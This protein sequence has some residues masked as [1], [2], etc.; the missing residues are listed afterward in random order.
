[1]STDAETLAVDTRSVTGTALPI[2][3]RTSRAYLAT[4]LAFVSCAAL[5]VFE[6]TVLVSGAWW[7]VLLLVWL[8]PWPNRAFDS[9]V[10]ARLNWRT[11]H[12]LLALAVFSWLFFRATTS[13]LDAALYWEIIDIAG[14]AR[15]LNYVVQDLVVGLITGTLLAPPLQRPFGR[16]SSAVAFV[17]ATPWIILTSAD[18]VFD[19]YS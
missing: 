16:D 12:S 17:V 9:T 8:M 14:S 11:L 7:L 6:P 13:L 19:L 18:T 2:R 5:D 1:M 4:S 3:P 15:A 10:P